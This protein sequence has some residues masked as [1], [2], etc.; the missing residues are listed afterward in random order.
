[1]AGIKHDTFETIGYDMRLMI[2]TVTALTA[3][4]AAADTRNV[5]AD[6]WVD[7]WFAMSA[8]GT[9][10]LEDSVPI[11]TERSFNKETTTVSIDL[12]AVIAIEAKD[13]KENDTGLEY[14]GTNRQQMGDGGMIAQFKDAATGETLAVTDAGMKCLVV[15]FAPLDPSCADQATPVAGEGACGFVATDI[16]ADWTASDFDDSEWPA[17]TVHSAADVSPKGGYDDVTWD[18]TAKLVWGAS[19]KQDNTLLCRMTISD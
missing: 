9:L 2:A 7:N 1:M 3:S 6:I 15:Q 14:I 16:P 11:T 17:A 10:V 12:P 5:T 19:L 8:N 13:F 4:A 18:D